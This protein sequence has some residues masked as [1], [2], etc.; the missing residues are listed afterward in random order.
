[1]LDISFNNIVDLFQLSHLASF[2]RLRTLQLN[3]N[4][5]SNE[6]EHVG[7]VLEAVPWLI[8]LDNE[9][10]GDRYRK[11]L[12]QS[13]FLKNMAVT[14]MQYLYERLAQ[15]NK[16]NLSL[17]NP[18]YVTKQWISKFN[19][20]NSSTSYTS[21]NQWSNIKSEPMSRDIIELMNGKLNMVVLWA[22]IF[23]LY[24]IAIVNPI[25]KAQSVFAM[26]NNL[27]PLICLPIQFTIEENWNCLAFQEMFEIHRKN[28]TWS[29]E[30]SLRKEFLVQEGKFGPQTI[31]KEVKSNKEVIIKAQNVDQYFL[32]HLE[33]KDNKYKDVFKE[34]VEYKIEIEDQLSN[35]KHFQALA[36]GMLARKNHM[37]MQ[38]LATDA[39]MAREA[40]QSLEKQTFESSVILIQVT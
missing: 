1:M 28:H 26:E 19:D 2:C 12:V 3:D 23:E 22:I 18:K 39:L 6:E 40:Q 17:K 14:G 32:E 25:M 30:T 20:Q 21:I 35:T 38:K 34:N 24:Q 8:E 15:A 4:P 13:I 33:Y 36:R 29:K 5:L 11:K 7:K 37:R 31:E 27:Y 10:I 16:K 9:H